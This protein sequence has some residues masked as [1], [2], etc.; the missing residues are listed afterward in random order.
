MFD[1][2]Y[3]GIQERYLHIPN[4]ICYREISMSAGTTGV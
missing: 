2:R 4:G 3:V 1:V